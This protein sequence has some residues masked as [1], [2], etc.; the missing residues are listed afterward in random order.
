LKYIN[1]K[2]ISDGNS[3]KDLIKNN[4]IKDKG[5]KLNKL[6]LFW[7]TNSQLYRHLMKQLF[8]YNRIWSRRYAF[9][10]DVNKYYKRYNNKEHQ[11]Q[12]KYKRINYYTSNF[13]QPLI[14]PILEIDNYYPD[15]TKFRINDNLYK[16]KDEILSYNFS[17]DK[18]D[19]NLNEE[20]VKKYLDNNETN[21]TINCCLIKKM[22]HVK[23]E[24]GILNDKIFFSS[25][26]KDYEENCNKKNI[27][28]KEESNRNLC[29]GSVFPCLKKDRKR[30]VF[31]PV[32]K[33]MFVLIRVYYYRPSA[34][35]IFTFD[36]KSY[37]FNF[38]D[39]IEPN[40][41]LLLKYLNEKKFLEI[42]IKE[43]S[44]ANFFIQSSSNFIIGMYN[45]KYSDVL[46]PLFKDNID[47]WKDKIYYYSNFDK[48]MIINLFS[49]RSFNDLYQYPVFPMLY[50]EIKLK[51][52]MNESIGFQ[53]LTEE[54]KERKNQ[55]VESYIYSK[56]SQDDNIEKYYF[57]L[58]YSNITYTCNYLIRVFPYSFIGIEYQGDGFDD[59]NRLFF[60]INI[61]LIQIIF[62][63]VDHVDIK[64]Y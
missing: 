63:H 33:I 3:L 53:D 30:F 39:I 64:N 22:Y 44:W 46:N 23:G 61:L 36:N 12:I 50:N 48:L 35:E 2:S 5:K 6:S 14:Y 25:A 27:N 19:N 57:N 18:F 26:R 10:R 56:E 59:P 13:Q 17:L 37:Y 4:Y 62:I 20:L 47:I 55:T 24:L 31:I 60:S 41:H 34:L 28:R 43:N 38:L 51:R 1:T 29:Y 49:N 54:A 9:F 42:K 21:K 15:F 40:N 7:K 45:Q 11:Y 58:F 16:N 8:V 52:V 32:D